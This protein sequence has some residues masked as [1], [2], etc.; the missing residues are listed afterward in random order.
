MRS[1]KKT[2]SEKRCN[3]YSNSSYIAR[4]T[5]ENLVFRKS[6]WSELP[7][8][9]IELV[10]IQTA[11][12]LLNT[13]LPH[14]QFRRCKCS[15]ASQASTDDSFR[16]MHRRWYP[17]HTFQ[18]HR[19]QAS[20]NGLGMLNS[21]FAHSKRPSP[22]HRSSSSSIRKNRAFCRVIQAASQSPASF[23]CTMDSRLFPQSICTLKNA[24][25]AG[26][27]TPQTIGSSWRLS[28]QWNNRDTMLRAPN[29]RS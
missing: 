14:N 4:P 18:R 3:T 20:G 25:Q 10:W 11:Y 28:R 21:H 6:A 19:P 17:Y 9:Q 16:N 26:R 24:L 8:I 13:Y 12:R 1:R 15:L 7:S 29:S 27:T 22:K 23:P 2:T 5:S